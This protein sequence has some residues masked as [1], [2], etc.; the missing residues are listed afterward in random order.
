MVEIDLSNSQPFFLIDKILKFYSSN[1]GLIQNPKSDVSMIL[2]KFNK[3]PQDVV[4][5]IEMIRNGI[6]YETLVER[7]FIE[8]SKIYERDH[9]KKE[10]FK[11][12]YGQNYMN[13]FLKKYFKAEF[14]HVLKLIGESKIKKYNQLALDLQS[15]EADFMLNGVVRGLL[16]EVLSIPLITIHDAIHQLTES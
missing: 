9:V 7:I 3:L 15:I 2:N 5:Y 11:L 14:P 10:L 16:D 8:S 12:F 4:N 1:E 13:F 6:L